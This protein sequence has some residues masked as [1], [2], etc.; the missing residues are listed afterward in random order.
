MLGSNYMNI[1]I[2][3]VNNWKYGIEKAINNDVREEI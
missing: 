2:I 3:K 1:A